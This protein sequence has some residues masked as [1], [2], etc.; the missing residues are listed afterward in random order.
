VSGFLDLP[1]DDAT[2]R[3]VLWDNWCRLYG[4]PA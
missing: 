2:K 1:L 3:K 4:M